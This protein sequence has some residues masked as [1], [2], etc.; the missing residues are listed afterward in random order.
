MSQSDFNKRVIWTGVLTAVLGGMLASA[1]GGI[2]RAVEERRHPERVQRRLED[3][4][5]FLKRRT[6]RRTHKRS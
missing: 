5:K 3:E 2:S 4:L 6:D 1:I